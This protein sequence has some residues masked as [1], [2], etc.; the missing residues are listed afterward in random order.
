[1]LYPGKIAHPVKHTCLQVWCWGALPA[2]PGSCSPG[3]GLHTGFGVCPCPFPVSLYFS[4]FSFPFLYPVFLLLPLFLF[5][6]RSVFTY[7]ACPLSFVPLALL[8][9]FL[10][11]SPPTLPSCTFSLCRQVP[12]GA[13]T[14]AGWIECT[15]EKSVN[16]KKQ[17]VLARESGIAESLEDDGLL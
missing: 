3:S 12:I 14:I 17:A 15:W 13:A 16:G 8:V 5:V 7:V 6:L 4:C 2:G 9:P 10:V 1:M 11:L